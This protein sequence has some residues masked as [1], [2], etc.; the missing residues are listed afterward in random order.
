M[1]LRG[2][3][4]A[5]AW[6]RSRVRQCGNVRAAAFFLNEVASPLIAPGAARC[7]LQ[8]PVRGRTLGSVIFQALCVV[9]RL[10]AVE[11][12]PASG[13][14]RAKVEFA[15]SPPLSS[16]VPPRGGERRF[17]RRRALCTRI[18][19]RNCVPTGA[20]TDDSSS[21]PGTRGPPAFLRARLK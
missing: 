21:R 7:R 20:S 12:R 19:A 18:V 13:A 3:C 8:R 11:I 10:D 9:L 15:S 4:R 6:G 17:R 2:E 16:L 14:S 5:L 1:H